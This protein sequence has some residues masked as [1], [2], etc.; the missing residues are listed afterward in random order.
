M[1]T[2][3]TITA[4][5]TLCTIAGHAHVQPCAVDI[6]QA[7]IPACAESPVVVSRL[8]QVECTLE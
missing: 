8:I 1:T 3:N 4:L 7:Y 2:R 6:V 5:S